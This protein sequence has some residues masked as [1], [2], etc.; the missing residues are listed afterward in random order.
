MVLVNNKG[1]GWL[2]FCCCHRSNSYMAKRFRHHLIGFKEGWRIMRAIIFGIRIDWW[3]HI[4]PAV[5]AT[6]IVFPTTFLMLDNRP[7]VTVA[8]ARFQPS[9]PMAGT[10]AQIIWEATASR[11]CDGEVI[12]HIISV[13][14]KTFE[15]SRSPTVYKGTIGVTISF[16]KSIDIPASIT[17]GP[18][19]YRPIVYRYRNFLQ[20]WLRDVWKRQD[21]IDDVLFVIRPN[22]HLNKPE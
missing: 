1:L 22:P 6:A 14:N 17:P 21:P 3:R 2:G 20:K 13:K 7:C 9:E 4:I 8:N 11:A 18:A 12:G 19:I 16:S 10:T 5:F 15:I